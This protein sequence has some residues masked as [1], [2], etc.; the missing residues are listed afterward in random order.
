MTWSPGLSWFL[1]LRYESFYIRFCMKFASRCTTLLLYFSSIPL[2]VKPLFIATT[3]RHYRWASCLLFVRIFTIHPDRNMYV[4]LM[5]WNCEKREC[6]KFWRLSWSCWVLS[7]C[8]DMMR[9][10][11]S[12]QTIYT[13]TSAVAPRERG[14]SHQWLCMHQEKGVQRFFYQTCIF[15]FWG[16]WEIPCCMRMRSDDVRVAIF[17]W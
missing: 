17:G 9:L 13:N 8:V 1:L 5:L 10:G 7:Q 6:W 12:I 14:L 15:A 4:H 2:G 3:L 16:R 11:N